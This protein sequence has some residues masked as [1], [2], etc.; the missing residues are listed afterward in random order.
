MTNSDLDNQKFNIG[1]VVI[2]IFS[3]FAVVAPSK[4]KLEDDVLAGIRINS[5]DIIEYIERQKIEIHRTRAHPTFAERFIR[6]FKKCLKKL[7]QMRKG[8]K[9]VFNGRI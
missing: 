4:A 2:D 5:N 3:K 6:T 8:V 1:M 9:I 7:K